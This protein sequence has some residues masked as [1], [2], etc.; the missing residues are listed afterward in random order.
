MYGLELV[1]YPEYINA[2]TAIK[3]ILAVSTSFAGAGSTQSSCLIHAVAL[4]TCNA[5]M[6]CVTIMQQQ[7]RPEGWPCAIESLNR[8]VK[9][10]FL[11]TTIGS[12]G[13]LVTAAVYDDSSLAGLQAVVVLLMIL[14]IVELVLWLQRRAAAHVGTSSSANAHSAQALAKALKKSTPE[15]M[16]IAS[17]I[18]KLVKGSLAKITMLSLQMSDKDSQAADTA[19]AAK[20]RLFVLIQELSTSSGH[21]ANAILV[22]ARQQVPS[23]AQCTENMEK[24]LLL[25]PAELCAELIKDHKDELHLIVLQ[26]EEREITTTEALSHLL[27]IVQRITQQ[28]GMSRIEVSNT[29]AEMA[30]FE[31]VPQLLSA[32]TDETV[33]D[34]GQ[35]PTLEIDNR[36]EN[37]DGA[38]FKIIE[39]R[40]K[41]TEDLDG[42]RLKRIEE[43]EGL[44]GIRLKRIEELE[45][46]V[47]MLETQ[48]KDNCPKGT[49]GEE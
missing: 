40:L 24:R 25:L 37:L 14:I 28:T 26:E 44:D 27:P 36:A 4:F 38:R 45:G 10:G 42:I 15:D 39:D 33:T 17:E 8:F 21:N 6:V 41:M 12:I 32:E 9:I 29:L 20:H 1:F 30:E 5:G 22:E 43:L 19:K 23:A 11:F 13:N 3:V 35:R 46:R 49:A 18:N 2:V 7:L 48:L 34:S 31:R 47:N 16:R